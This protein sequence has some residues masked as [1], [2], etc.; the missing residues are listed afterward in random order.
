MLISVLNLAVK[1]REQIG[2]LDNMKT[3]GACTAL[4]TGDNH[5]AYPTN[6]GI[7]GR[8][9]F[10]W[11]WDDWLSDYDGRNLSD[12]DKSHGG[13]E[14]I[15]VIG[16][17]EEDHELY[18]CPSDT[19][20]RHSGKVPRSYAPN[21]YYPEDKNFDWAMYTPGMISHANYALSRRIS[22]VSNP[23]QSIVFSEFINTNKHN[24]IG[25]VGMLADSVNPN[26]FIHLGQQWVH[27][28]FESNY[29]MV[30]GSGKFMKYEDTM[31]VVK[32]RPDGKVRTQTDPTI[33]SGGGVGNSALGTWWDCN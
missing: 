16:G 17:T 4:F 12:M 28:G 21:Q 9:D 6:C 33:T 26:I 20:T 8:A 30:D 2:C 29:I 13:N 19:L 1:K 32:D 25:V 22:G 7:N 11:S 24:G 27:G 10:H 18:R 3:I 23:S 5:G 14:L 31:K 15:A